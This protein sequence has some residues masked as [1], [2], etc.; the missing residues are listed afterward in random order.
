MDKFEKAFICYLDEDNK[1]LSGYFKLVNASNPNFI[2]FESNSNTI[3]I[4]IQRILKIKLKGGHD[5]DI[6]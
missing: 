1:K 4:P 6:R 2:L 5:K 3:A